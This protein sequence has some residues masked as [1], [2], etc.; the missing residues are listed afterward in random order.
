MGGQARRTG[1]ANAGLGKL[2][3]HLDRLLAAPDGQLLSR[4]VAARDEEA[5]ADLVRRHGPM[6]LGVCRRVLRHQQDAEDALQATFIILAR[7]ASSVVKRAS[8]GS[9]LY[10]VAYRTALQARASLARRRG[11][12]AQ[13]HDMP[14]P[15]AG[16]DDWRPL[17]DEE[18]GRLPE[19]YRAAVV[20]C[21]LEGRPRKDAAGL[22]GIPEGTL[23][24]RLTAARRLLARRLSGRGLAVTA[25]ALGAALAGEAS[26][27][28]PAALVAETSKA[29][30]LAAAGKLAADATTAAA[31]TSEVLK[32][33]FLTKLKAVVAV[34]AVVVAL[35]ATGVAYRVSDEPRAQAAPP[36]AKVPSEPEALKRENEL[37]KLNLRVTLEKL[38]ATEAEL[39]ALKARAGAAPAAT[40]RDKLVGVW[41]AAGPRTPADVTVEFTGD[42]KVTLR[43]DGKM[44]NGERTYALEGD[45][46]KLTT[47]SPDGQEHTATATIKRLTDEELVLREESGIEETF[48]RRK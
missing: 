16:P 11:R 3:G 27:A 45:K 9:W 26:A 7:K 25:A 30:A 19:K 24:S 6:V 21:D 12:E 23:S 20:L 4:F 43:A 29:A 22:L 42:G 38:E 2:I 34:L 28:L 33:M 37:L 8:V 5:F 1:M 41:Q 46:L 17:L 18:L 13:V 39:R 47:K 48:K 35:G 31:L 36:G 44:P 40:T 10:G 14:H 15:A 32:A